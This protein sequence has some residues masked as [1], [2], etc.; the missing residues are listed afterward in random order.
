MIVFMVHIPQTTG[1]PL[2]FLEGMTKIFEKNST[3]Y[4][5]IYQVMIEDGKY[6]KVGIVN[7]DRIFAVLFYCNEYS[8]LTLFPPLNSIPV[9]CALTNNNMTMINKYSKMDH[10]FLAPTFTFIHEE[11]FF[12]HFPT[13]VFHHY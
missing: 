9:V 5:N 10:F 8:I 3:N 6:D 13:Q 2:L 7:F 4:P 12:E 11:L 1:I